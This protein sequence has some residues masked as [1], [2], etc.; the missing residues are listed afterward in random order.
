MFDGL[1]ILLVSLVL[2]MLFVIGFIGY[3]IGDGI[4]APEQTESLFVTN[5]QYG[6]ANTAIGIGVT[7]G[8]NVAV[9]TSVTPAKYYFMAN[10]MIIRTNK[11]T[12]LQII[13]NAEYTFVCRYGRW[14]G[15][16]LRC[17]LP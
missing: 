6:A 8:S 10:Q 16:L 17:T 15:K 3:F 11:Q 7:S 12:F 5:T 14:S 9:T 1:K 13:P 2:F 4:K